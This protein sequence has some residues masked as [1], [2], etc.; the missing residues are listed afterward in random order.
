[1]PKILLFEST[2]NRLQ[3]STAREIASF[4]IF[5]YVFFVL[6]SFQIIENDAMPNKLNAAIWLY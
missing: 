4:C 6:F 2:D 5:L 3:Y 1:M